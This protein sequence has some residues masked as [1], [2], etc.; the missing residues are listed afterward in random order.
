MTSK[1]KKH[2]NRTRENGFQEGKKN[3][4]SKEK[5][6]SSTHTN[7]IRM[8]YKCDGFKV[9]IFSRV[10]ASEGTVKATVPST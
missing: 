9:I 1:K 6:N 7:N 5:H 2:L 8:P 4:F 3:S 10:K